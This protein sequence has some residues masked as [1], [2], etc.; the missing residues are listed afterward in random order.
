MH[1]AEGAVDGKT[2][3]GS[4]CGKRQC[5]T[6]HMDGDVFMQLIKAGDKPHHQP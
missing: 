5:T 6:A 1:D 4:A 3:V 2:L